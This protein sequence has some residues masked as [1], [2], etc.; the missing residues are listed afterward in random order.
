MATLADIMPQSIEINLYHPN[1]K[2]EL[3]TTIILVGQYSPEFYHAQQIILREKDLYSDMDGLL[4]KEGAEFL[5]KS[6]I[7]G[8]RNMEIMDKGKRRKLKFTPENLD[9][10]LNKMPFII[11]QITEE[12]Q[13]TAL[14]FRSQTA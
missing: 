14:F 12:V 2:E 8:W 7:K 11:D 9:L 4:T 10:V 1:T 3:E 6:I 13:R 5:I